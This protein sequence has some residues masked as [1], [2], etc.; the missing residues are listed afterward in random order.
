MTNRLENFQ[1]RESADSRHRRTEI[2]LTVVVI[3]LLVLLSNLSRTADSAANAESQDD[4]TVLNE[5]DVRVQ[6]G[7]TSDMS[8]QGRAAG[9]SA[10]N[11]TSV[12]IDTNM[13][14]EVTI[15]G[16]EVSLPL[17]SEPNNSVVT[18]AGN[19]LS[20]SVNSNLTGGDNL[21]IEVDSKTKVDID[22]D[23]EWT[24]KTDD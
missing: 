23:E 7:V 13:P 9:G 16:E 24:I 17:G 4:T 12:N 15:N 6:A 20:F 1:R 10:S 19:I 21:D 18:D 14:A 2:I 5:T 3:N 8:L 11:Q 22:N